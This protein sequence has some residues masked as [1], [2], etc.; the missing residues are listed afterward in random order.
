MEELGQT[1]GAGK[2]FI[3]LLRKLSHGWLHSMRYTESD[4]DALS[5][6]GSSGISG[7]RD[8]NLVSRIRRLCQTCLLT[9]QNRRPTIRSIV[10]S[11]SYY[12][13]TRRVSQQ[14]VS[15]H[16]KCYRSAYRRDI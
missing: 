3:V 16:V 8:I 12:N 4:L 15:S 2:K 6:L 11:G 14:G 1:L 13:L 7:S 9:P 5:D 10:V